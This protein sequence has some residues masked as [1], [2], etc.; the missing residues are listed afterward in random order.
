MENDLKKLVSENEKI[1]YEG[2]P[3]KKCFI[4][5][6]IFNPVMPFA[7]IWGLIDFGILGGSLASRKRSRNNDFSNSFYAITSYAIMDLPRRCNL[8]F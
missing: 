4:F 6:S 7:L 3:D 8:F 2:K 1:L 5:E